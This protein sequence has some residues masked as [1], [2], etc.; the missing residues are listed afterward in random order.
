MIVIPQVVDFGL[1]SDDE[2]NSIRQPGN[3]GDLEAPAAAEPVIGDSE[4]A[5]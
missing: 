5:P 2:D 4:S 1:C 3:T